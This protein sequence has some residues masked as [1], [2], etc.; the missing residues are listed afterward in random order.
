MKR[1]LDDFPIISKLEG[2]VVFDKY[3]TDNYK[4]DPPDF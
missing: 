1:F 2:L 4:D 3:K